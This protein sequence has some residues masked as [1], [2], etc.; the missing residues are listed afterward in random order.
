MFLT[1]FVILAVAVLYWIPVRR[2][3]ARWG[4]TP[5]DLTRFMAGIARHVDCVKEIPV[6]KKLTNGGQISRQPLRSRAA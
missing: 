2:W 1:L 4:T 6:G 3:M 5:S